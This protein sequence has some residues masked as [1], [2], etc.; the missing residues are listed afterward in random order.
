MLSVRLSV[1]RI[2]NRLVDASERGSIEEPY[3]VG[4]FFGKS[5]ALKKS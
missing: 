1:W 2:E 3:L 5:L 4:W